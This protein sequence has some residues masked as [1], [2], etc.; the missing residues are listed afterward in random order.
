MSTNRSKSILV[1]LIAMIAMFAVL[2]PS[3]FAS[4]PEVPTL[5]V[6]GVTGSG[7][8]LLGTLN[9]E[10]TEP[11]EAGTYQFVY[12]ATSSGVCKGAGEAVAP[13]APGVS[14]GG[15]HEELPGES[16]GGLAAGTEYAACLVVTEPGK[17]TPAVSAPV[18]FKTLIAPETP[19]HEEAEVTDTGSATLKA[20][21]NPN[22]PGEPDSYRFRYRPSETECEGEHQKGIPGEGF[23]SS[24]PFE[25]PFTSQ[26]DQGETVQATVTGLLPLTKYT[27]C[28]FTSNEASEGAL[29]QPVTFETPVD[30]PTIANLSAAGVHS[31]ELTLSA[32]V[33]PGGAATSVEVTGAG[34]ATLTQA[35]P[36]SKTPFSVQ[37]HLSGLTPS[38]KYVAHLTASNEAGRTEAEVAFTTTVAPSREEIGSH[39]QNKTFAGFTA[40]L[41]DCRAVELV[42]P[43]NEVGDVYDPGG[44]ESAH[45]DL[46]TTARP[47]RSSESGTAVTYLGDP[48]NTGGNGDTAKGSGNQFLARRAGGNWSTTNISPLVAESES[49]SDARSYKSFSPDLSVGELASTAPLVGDTP[50]PQGPENCATLYATE[51]TASNTVAYKPLF[52]STLVPGECGRTP[53]STGFSEP[54]MTGLFFAG[55]TPDHAVKLLDSGAALTAPAASSENLGGNVYASTTEGGLTVLNVLPNGSVEPH[56]VAGGPS[57]EAQNGPDLGNVISPDGERTIWSSVERGPG[58]ENVMV[59]LPK[60]L[61]A[62]EKALTPEARTVQL[63]AAEPGAAGPSGGGQF[64]AGSVDGEKVFFT[65]CHALTTEATTHEEGGCLDNVEGKN[66]LVKTGSDLY[67]YQFGGGSGSKL[68]DITV[69]SDESDPLGADVQG[70]VASSTDGDFVYFVAGG[71]LGAAPNSRGQAPVSGRCKKSEEAQEAEREGKVPAANGCNLF[72][73][74]FNGSA[75]EAP[76]FI[77]RLAPSDNIQDLVALNS[78]KGVGSNSG[79]GRERVGDWNPTLGSRIAQATP[80]GGALVFSS[81]QDLTGYDQ[82]NLASLVTRGASGLSEDDANQIF[83]YNAGA[84]SLT[85]AS[86]NPRNETLDL[87][88]FVE[89][90]A[91]YL[92]VSSS[93]TFMH[94]W[95]NEAGTELFFDTSQPLAEADRNKIQDVY[96]WAAQG[97]PSCPTSTSVFGGC[98]FLLTSGEAAAFAF[99]VDTDRTGENVFVTNRGPLHGVGPAGTKSSLFDLRTGG[100]VDQAPAE[101]CNSAA[102]CPAAPVSIPAGSAPRSSSIAGND[103]FGPAPELKKAVVQMRAE[104]L[105][106]ALRV[107][108]RERARKRRGSCEARARKRYGAKK[109]KTE[110]RKKS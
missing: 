41:P 76:V 21:L 17:T 67:E 61:Y 88:A 47:F 36:A 13:A 39:C 96:E 23:T 109:A 54:R 110:R 105:A 31:T 45:E 46:I 92:P 84:N 108:R 62:R 50:S 93:Y 49:A 37:Q 99:L 55:E 3:A 8:T 5:T 30:V 34:I 81:T 64:W 66:D 80:S 74:H 12:R 24:E 69:D 15:E 106:G 82:A 98:I 9:P 60:A 38:T 33:S 58:L 77:A 101:G 65:D 75:W 22:N 107:C 95:I 100:G 51:L 7:V 53:I 52:T 87:N 104:K 14:L 29:G 70:V 2:V 40:G 6:G 43:A 32:S 16:I 79:G 19:D 26:G 35:L 86:C 94:R 68:R 59:A 85:C 71:A 11:R 48:E 57:E 25:P 90:T 103:N 72:L 4:T 63:D 91:T 56:A 44:S 78:P 83:V 73:L 20:T 102:T 89:G 28:V 27:F 18:T 97:T 1:L 42:S 10:A